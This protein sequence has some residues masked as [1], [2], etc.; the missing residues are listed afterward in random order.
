[1]MKRND[2]E[3]EGLFHDEEGLWF[4]VLLNIL[5][6]I[7]A[8]TGKAEYEQARRLILEPKNGCL[9][10]IAAALGLDTG[11]LHKKIIHHLQKKRITI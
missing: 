9:P 2:P 1:M 3:L 10:F 8:P 6:E 7:E 11:E 5:D 4:A